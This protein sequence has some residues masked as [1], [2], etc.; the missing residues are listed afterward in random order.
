MA[1]LMAY[2][3]TSS[4]VKGSPSAGRGKRGKNYHNE[5]MV[6]GWKYYLGGVM[7]L[8]KGMQIAVR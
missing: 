5:N 7:A 1:L 8:G 4:E 2:G 6:T 3:A